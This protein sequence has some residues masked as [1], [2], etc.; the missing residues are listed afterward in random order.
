MSPDEHFCEDE[1]VKEAAKA[2]KTSRFS[3]PGKKDSKRSAVDAMNGKRTQI[4]SISKHRIPGKKSEVVDEVLGLLNLSLDAAEKEGWMDR[5]TAFEGKTVDDFPRIVHPMMLETRIQ[6]PTAIIVG[7][8]DPLYLCGLVQKRLCTKGMRKFA[9]H[10]G[11]HDIPRA[12]Q[13]LDVAVE[14]CKWAIGKAQMAAMGG[15]Y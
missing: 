1:I 2:Q 15:A 7:K 5:A 10:A 6:I 9:L 13:D 12:G 4:K 8:E 11:G 3:F 14:S